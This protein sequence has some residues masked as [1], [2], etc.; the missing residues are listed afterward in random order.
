MRSIIATICL[1]GVMIITSCTSD[2]SKEGFKPVANKKHPYKLYTVTQNVLSQQDFYNLMVKKFVIPH[3]MAKNLRGLMVTDLFNLENKK[4]A[5][6]Y[7][8]YDKFAKDISGNFLPE[9]EVL[10]HEIWHL[11]ELGGKFHKPTDL[12]GDGFF[13]LTKSESEWKSISKFR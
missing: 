6:I 5:D 4:A 8:M 9:F 10:G 11:Y 13:V 2:S 1:V 3:N 7:V 12:Y